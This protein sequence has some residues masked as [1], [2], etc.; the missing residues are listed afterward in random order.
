LPHVTIA[1]EQGCGSRWFVVN[2]PSGTDFPLSLSVSDTLAVST[3]DVATE[4]TD[5]NGGHIRDLVV[6]LVRRSAAV[7][8][9]NGNNLVWSRD[10]RWLFYT[11]RTVVR[12][13]RFRVQWRDRF[14]PLAWYTV[15]SPI[16]RCSVFR[17]H[18]DGTGRQLVTS[19][20]A[21]AIARLT[22]LPDDRT[23][24]FEKIPSDWGLWS[25][26]RLGLTLANA[27]RFG[28][29]ASIDESTI[30]GGAPR[31]L[32]ANARLPAVQP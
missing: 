4:L 3:S 25:H 1:V 13:V 7:W 29:Q 14:D 22:V 9:G 27:V 11:T 28:P 23:V 2:T 18:A 24:V 5:D 16:Y 10:G 20:L 6:P 30:G 8:V 19:T 32:F 15:K 26:R 17:V 31:T 21:Y 12:T